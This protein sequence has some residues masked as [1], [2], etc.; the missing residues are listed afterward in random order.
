MFDGMIQFDQDHKRVANNI[1][2]V[3]EKMIS[4]KRK[5]LKD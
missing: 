3:K 4:K 5:L 2:A 1:E